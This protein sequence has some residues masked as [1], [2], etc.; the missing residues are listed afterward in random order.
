MRLSPDTL[1]EGVVPPEGAGAGSCGV[2]ML[3]FFVLSVR[4][5]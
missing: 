5:G 2:S 1:S 3:M 4:L